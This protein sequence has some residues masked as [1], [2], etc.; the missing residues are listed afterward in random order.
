M[1]LVYVYFSLSFFVFTVA[2]NSFSV[3]ASNDLTV[4]HQRA[5]SLPITTTASL[6]SSASHN[7]KPDNSHH[8]MKLSTQLAVSSMAGIITSTHITKSNHLSCFH[9]RT[10]SLPL[11]E[12]ETTP[13][14][15]MFPS[16]TSSSSSSSLLH[17]FDNNNQFH[18]V[19]PSS[20]LINHPKNSQSSLSSVH[21]SSN[22]SITTPT[23]ELNSSSIL[24][25]LCETMCTVRNMDGSRKHLSACCFYQFDKQSNKNSNH[26][27]VKSNL[28]QNRINIIN[29]NHIYTDPEPTTDSDYLLMTSSS[30]NRKGMNGSLDFIE[31]YKRDIQIDSNYASAIAFTNYT[32]IYPPDT[33]I[34]PSIIIS[35]PN[36][37]STDHTNP[38]ISS[39]TVFSSSQSSSSSSPSTSLLLLST[40]VSSAPQSSTV[41]TS[42]TTA[43]SSSSSSASALRCKGCCN[44]TLRSM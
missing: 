7:I 35:A 17:S 28:S 30:T 2:A 1:I 24:R 10:R 31:Q 39:L 6:T 41:L 8:R 36:S 5:F 14:E 11:T 44:C 9:Q 23:N 22:S 33:L 12:E 32:E 19:C 4:S 20:G 27:S 37:S 21:S 13:V 16:A 38:N 40:P 26:N 3:V 18:P 15:T 34:L 43:A 29:N 42:T 25:K